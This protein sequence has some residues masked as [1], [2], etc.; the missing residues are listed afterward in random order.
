MV[1]SADF[2]PRAAHYSLNLQITPDGVRVPGGDWL[3]TADFARSGQDLVL[4]GLD[5][6][7][8]LVPNYF[9]AESPAPLITD[10]G[11]R[12]E[13]SLVEVLAGPRAPMQF[14]EAQLAQASDASGAIGE[15]LD[16]QGTVHVTRADGSQADLAQGD[17]VFLKDVIQAAAD[18]K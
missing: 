14:A 5:G 16:V 12:L 7:S 15:V 2:D 18:G 9:A 4:H 10:S 8:A 6:A 17:A 1:A 3:L 13:G 11:A